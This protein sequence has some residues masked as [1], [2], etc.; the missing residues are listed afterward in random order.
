MDI[1]DQAQDLD[2]TFRED[3]IKTK[4]K[5]IEASYVPLTSAEFCDVCET[6]T[7]CSTC[8]HYVAEDYECIECG[9]EIDHK[10]RKNGYDTCIDC[11][12][13][14]EEHTIKIKKMRGDY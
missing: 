14:M 9:G 3:A 4:R 10:R 13:F 5:E 11:A 6:P 12:R 7:E 8:E 1:F 2:A